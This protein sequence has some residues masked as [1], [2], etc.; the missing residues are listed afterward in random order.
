M[1]E[2]LRNGWKN[3]NLYLNK[4]RI[5]DKQFS[6]NNVFSIIE[7]MVEF[8][9][10]VCEWASVRVSETEKEFERKNDYEKESDI[11]EN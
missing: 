1:L 11:K 6:I 2:N 5:F 8:N 9:V 7:W 3:A 10:T 4:Y